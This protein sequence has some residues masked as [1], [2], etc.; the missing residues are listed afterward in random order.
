MAGRPVDREA[1]RFGNADPRVAVA[2]MEPFAAKI[3]RVAS[4]VLCV[5]A[6][7]EPLGGFQEQARGAAFHKP[8]RGADAGGASPHDDHIEFAGHRLEV[9]LGNGASKVTAAIAPPASK[10]GASIETPGRP[11]DTIA[12]AW[13]P[14]VSATRRGRR[15]TEIDQAVPLPPVAP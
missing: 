2:R 12:R 6:A 3:E 14:W 11:G 4:E 8:T 1:G 15:R 13:P 9:R 5:G 10:P 7:P